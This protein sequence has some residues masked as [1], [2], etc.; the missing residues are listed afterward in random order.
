M[1]RKNKARKDVAMEEINNNRDKRRINRRR[2]KQ[3][4][5]ENEKWQNRRNR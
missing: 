1:K 2:K 5:I 4:K 3:M